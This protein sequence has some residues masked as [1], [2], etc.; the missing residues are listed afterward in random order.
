MYDRM[1]TFSEQELSRLHDA[2]MAILSG[3]G[4]AFN[5]TEAL[6][7]FRANGFKVDGKTVFMDEKAVRAAV[8]SAPARFKMTAR[9][10]AKS[11]HIG[12]D[13]W[14]FVPTYGP[15]FMITRTGEKRAG[16]MQDYDNFCKLVQTSAHIDM[17]G[18]K[19]VE[20]QDV[21]SAT[22]YLDML[23][24]NILLCDKP[25]MGSTDNVQAA[26]DTMEMAAMVFADGDRTK[27]VDQ[28][29]GLGLIN[30]LSPL[31][32][33]QE[34]AGGIVE[35]AR[36]RQPMI[37]LNMIMAGTSGPI[38]LPGL[39][40]LMNAEILA[41]LVLSQLVGP[42]TPVI[43]GTTSCPTDMRTGAACIGA[44]E[45][46]IINSATTQL[47]RFYDLPCRTGG[48][49]TDAL[50]PDAQALAEGALTLSTS[51]RNGANFI[52]HSC[53]MMGTYIGNNMEKWLIDE[54]LCGMVRRMLTPIEITP[55]S[56]DLDTIQA[57]GIGGTYLTQPSTLKNCRTAF[58]EKKAYCR[59]EHSR[60]QANGSKRVDETAS[61]ALLKRLAEYEKPPIDPG[62]ETALADFITARKNGGK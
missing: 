8:E 28:H 14:V 38:G 53:G 60:W 22:A 18:F 15:P 44:P 41:G 56:I 37:I 45:T 1:Q 30:P 55:E 54:E 61:E 26:R 62:L 46:V 16:T 19:H 52:L 34:M 48:S 21:P 24:S 7:I 32:F 29:V 10:P 27:L 47:A 4:V 25:F 5:D 36:C 23:F 43:Y 31:Q 3:T 13:D 58:Y 20:P 51:V 9:N 57:V 2:A 11:V 33:S 50:V 49:L 35:Y 6:E 40:A 59:D 42:G 17:N 12:L 39:L